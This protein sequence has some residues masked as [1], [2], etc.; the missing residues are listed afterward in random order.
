MK[1]LKQIKNPIKEDILIF[2]KEFDKAV[3]SKV[4]IINVVMKYM[5]RS[6]GKNIRPILTLH[7]PTLMLTQSQHMVRSLGSI[8]LSM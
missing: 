3:D 1:G 7:Y 4:H 2:K 8:E 6:R 5:M